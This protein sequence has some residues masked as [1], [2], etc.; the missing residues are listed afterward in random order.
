MTKLDG[1]RTAPARPATAGWRRRPAARGGARCSVRAAGKPPRHTPP[2]RT[3][4]L[5]ASRPHASCQRTARAPVGTPAPG[6]WPMARAVTGTQYILRPGKLQQLF[7]TLFDGRTQPLFPGC[8]VVDFSRFRAFGACRRWA[9]SALPNSPPS[10]F[11]L[12]P[13]PVRPAPR[14]AAQTSLRTG[15]VKPRCS[16]PPLL[17][18]RTPFASP[19]S[20]CARLPR[21]PPSAS[22]GRLA[23]PAASTPDDNRP[24]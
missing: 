22:L 20:D 16:G 17:T 24:K 19:G 4:D 1:P 3:P 21:H 10:S 23:D 18:P 2:A 6:P 11:S 14:P 7:S 13:W 15:A 5:K 9:S 12:P 8:F